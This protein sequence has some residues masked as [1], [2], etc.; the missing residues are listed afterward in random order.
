MVPLEEGPTLLA[1]ADNFDK[2]T[3]LL[4]NQNA[5]LRYPRKDLSCVLSVCRV[6]EEMALR[7]ELSLDQY[8]SEDL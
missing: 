1:T 5:I 4:P 8:D 7:D 6:C 3:F 2:H